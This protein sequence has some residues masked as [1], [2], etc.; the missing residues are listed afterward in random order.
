MAH[1]SLLVVFLL[2]WARIGG[3]IMA[4]PIYSERAIPM[5][6]K[7][8]LS[9]A[10]A[11]ILTPEQMAVA[12]P[13]SSD[14]ASFV[15]LL[16]EQ[17]LLG[18]AFALVFVVIYRSAESAGE[19]IGQQMGV[20]LGTWMGGD[21]DSQTHSIGQLYHIVASLIF[22]A[23]DGQ[24]WVILGLGASLNAMPVTHVTL[25]QNLAGTLMSLGTAAV[26]FAV[27]LA[28]PLLVTLLL[29][30]IITGLIGRSI[31]ALNLFVIG[32]PLKVALA[33]AGLIIAAPFTVALLSQYLQRLPTIRLW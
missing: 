33:V 12:G 25:S 22:L 10:I 19:L 1:P 28:L 27:G 17:I 29:A 16:G 5:L 2:V 30:D 21:G 14:P 26:M 23:L 11:G 13:I 9:A 24:H 7:A 20:T 4:A 31:P 3:A 32:L 18:L 8:G 15:V 6:V